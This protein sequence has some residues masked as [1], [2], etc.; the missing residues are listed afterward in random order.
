VVVVACPVAGGRA[1][2]A[3][4]PLPIG[5]ETDTKTMGI[6]QWWPSAARKS[7][8]SSSVFYLE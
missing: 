6:V 8:C 3:T 7:G 5:S 1:V 2:L 4:N